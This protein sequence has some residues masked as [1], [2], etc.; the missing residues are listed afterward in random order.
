MTYAEFK[1][2]FLPEF[3]NIKSFNGKVKYAKE[4]LGTPIG[5]G[6]GRIVF[7]IDGEK[8]LKLAKNT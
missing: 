6:T 3:R 7:D 2:N 5:S 1:Q 4:R 8:V